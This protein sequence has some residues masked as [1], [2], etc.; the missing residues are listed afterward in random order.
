MIELFKLLF[1]IGVGALIALSG[2]A[3]GAFLMFRGTRA[4]PG[5]KLFGGVPKGQVFSIKD[6]LEDDPDQNESE[7]Q[8]LEKTNKFLKLFQE[9][10][11]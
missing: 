4:I 6:P 10:K 9:E 11:K 8:I 5:E 3:L 1:F 2:V 7:K